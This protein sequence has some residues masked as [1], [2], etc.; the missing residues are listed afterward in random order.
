MQRVTK[1]LPRSEQTGEEEISELPVACIV[2]EPVR[3]PAPPI[4]DAAR[5]VR[6]FISHRPPDFLIA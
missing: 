6:R 2:V 4:A 3:R 1:R 5:K